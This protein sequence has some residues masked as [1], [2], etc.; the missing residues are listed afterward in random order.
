MT[1]WRLLLTRPADEAAT[2]GSFLAGQGIFSSSLPLL[3]IVPIAA[4][5]TMRQVIQTLE[6]FCAIIVVSKPAA[7]IASS[8]SSGFGQCRPLRSGSASARRQRRSS[9]LADWM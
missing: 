1:G 5:D 7:R 2:L 6:R 8:C 4:T 3:D 9:S